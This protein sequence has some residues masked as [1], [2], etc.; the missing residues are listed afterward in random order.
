MSD[1]TPTTEE[2]RRAVT[3]F[4][5]YF[6]HPRA[7]EFDGDLFDRW[8][9]E[10]Q[11]QARKAEREYFIQYLQSEIKSANKWSE[12]NKNYCTPEDNVKN[13]MVIAAY[14][15]LAETLIANPYRQGEEQ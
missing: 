10:V 6:D 14:E 2:V 12:E 7:T 3:S 5:E 13:S 9:A 4:N 8:L 15:N 11:A 1:Y